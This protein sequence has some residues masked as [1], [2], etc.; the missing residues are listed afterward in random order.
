MKKLVRLLLWVLGSLFA[1]ILLM[2]A[3][4]A[5]IFATS[6]EADAQ[7]RAQQEFLSE[8]ARRNLNPDEFVGPQRIKSHPNTY[9]YVWANPSNADQIVTL[10]SYLPLGVESWLLHDGNRGDFAPYCD[11]TGAGCH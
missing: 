6:T 8:C 9:G 11:N 1:V 4:Q 10:V 5:V 2:A 3:H 7:A